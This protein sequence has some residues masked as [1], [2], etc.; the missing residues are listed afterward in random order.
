MTVLVRADGVIALAGACPS[1]D[2]EALRRH[3]VEHPEAAVDWRDCLSAHTAVVQVLLAAR[4]RVTGPAGDPLLRRWVEP[5]L[6][7]E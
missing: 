1:E 4:R 7:A 5:L 2:A 3:L 6:G